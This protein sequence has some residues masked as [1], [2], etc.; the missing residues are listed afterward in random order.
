MGEGKCLIIHA[1]AIESNFRRHSRV[2]LQENISQTNHYRMIPD[3]GSKEGCPWNCEVHACYS[4]RKEQCTVPM[5]NT[6]KY[7]VKQYLIVATQV[8]I[9][10]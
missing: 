1:G 6:S 5:H 4:V 8:F 9:A 10:N 7:D 3:K 2:H